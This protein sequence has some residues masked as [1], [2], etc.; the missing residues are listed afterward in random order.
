M[1][2]TKGTLH[3]LKR[4]E[5]KK[6]EISIAPLIDMVFI[7]LLFFLVT[8]SFS[9]ETGVEV[10]R[11]V[12]ATATPAGRENIL[13]AVTERGTVHINERAVDLRTLRTILERELRRHPTGTVIIA[14][15][16]SSKT[17]IVVDVIDECKLAG[18][19]KISLASTVEK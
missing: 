17:G 8:T 19:K 1:V 11:P 6:P 14:A 12:A 18:A 15:D 9:R 3:S 5:R 4:K 10:S 7:L 13:V 16:K 2:T